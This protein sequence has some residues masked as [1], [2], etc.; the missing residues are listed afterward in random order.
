MPKKATYSRPIKE[1]GFV[2]PNKRNV[3]P[4]S[5][6]Y[7]GDMVIDDAPYRINLWNESKDRKT[8]SLNQ[9]PLLTMTL[10]IALDSASVKRKFR[11]LRPKWSVAKQKQKVLA[12]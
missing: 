2:Q 10:L 4:S 1:M 7:V 3:S 6:D 5:P 8:P 9:T 12:K 11:F